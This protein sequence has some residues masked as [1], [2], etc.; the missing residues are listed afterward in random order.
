LRI[1]FLNARG[2]RLAMACLRTG[3][4]AMQNFTTDSLTGRSVRFRVRDLHLPEPDAVLHELHG[5]DVLE[6]TVVDVSDD[7]SPHNVFVVVSVHGLRQPC[8]L[9]A[10]RILPSAAERRAATEGGAR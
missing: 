5:G 8:I 10:T 2:I 7:G 4:D 6:G 9:S 1:A 3:V